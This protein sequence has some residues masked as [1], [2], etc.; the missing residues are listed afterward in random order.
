M[1]EK[2]RIPGIQ[3][4]SILGT[5][6][7]F[8]AQCLV[9]ATRRRKVTARIQ[10]ARGPVNTE[11]SSTAA[12]AMR[13]RETERERA[14]CDNVFVLNME[15]GRQAVVGPTSDVFMDSNLKME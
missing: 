1:W 14:P 8:Q 11:N 5:L 7:L 2:E 10:G 15:V 4:A 6:T 3:P 12:T 13:E 9:R